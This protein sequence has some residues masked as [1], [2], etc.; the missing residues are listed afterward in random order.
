M[1]TKLI[2]TTTTTF[3]SCD[4]K[5]SSTC[6]L[7]HNALN[8]NSSLRNEWSCD[9]VGVENIFQLK[10]THHDGLR[11][12]SDFIILKSLQLRNTVVDSTGNNWNNLDRSIRYES[13]SLKFRKLL[14]THNFRLAYKHGQG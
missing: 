11:Y 7:I 6:S 14:K 3:P 8:T 9:L 2:A 10:E 13:D 4:Y 5:N 1:Y 12:S